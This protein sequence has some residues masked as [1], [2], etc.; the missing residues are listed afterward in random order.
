MQRII[1]DLEWNQAYYDRKTIRGIQLTG[2]IIQIGAVKVDDE[3][4]VIDTFKALVKPVYYRELHRKVSQITGLTPEDLKLGFLFKEAMK[5]FRNWCGNDFCLL[6]WGPDDLEILAENLLIHKLSPKWIPTSYDVQRIYSRWYRNEER[7]HALL[8]AVAEFDETASQ[9]HDALHDA[10][11]AAI[12][13]RHLD[14][15]TAIRDYTSIAPLENI[16]PLS[17]TEYF[18]FFSSRDEALD[19]KS[20][21]TFSCPFCSATTRS[22]GWVTKRESRVGLGICDSGDEFFIRLNFS[23]ASGAKFR[24][25][26]LVYELTQERRDRYETILEQALDRSSK[27]CHVTNCEESMV[28]VG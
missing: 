17:Q 24:P 1:L 8:D 15:E 22:Y 11:N 3:Y 14:M 19:D 9:A 25:R 26:R 2:E 27:H 28:T 7:R 23:R 13:C 5:Y 12:V 6:T 20:I 16:Y 18:R 4:R 21:T 10:K